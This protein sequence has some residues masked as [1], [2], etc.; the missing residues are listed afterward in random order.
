MAQLQNYYEYNGELYCSQFPSI[1][2]QT[3]ETDGTGPEYCG[4]CKDYGCWNGV[5]IGYCENCAIH[6]YNG[7]RGR[8]L[9]YYGVES[10][11]TEN[12]N[13]IFTTYLKNVELD[14][15]GDINLENSRLIIQ[16]EQIDKYLEEQ[17]REYEKHCSVEYGFSKA[18]NFI[19]NGYGSNY[20]NGYDS[21]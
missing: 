21:Y 1:W 18:S 2:I 4:N 17:D 20:D 12:G 3:H 8:G 11:E 5:F 10:T 6:I 19:N 16:Q 15:I 7:S 9:S 14:D 13:S